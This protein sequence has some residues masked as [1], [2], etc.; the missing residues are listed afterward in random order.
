MVWAPIC[1]ATWPVT[2]LTLCCFGTEHIQ[3]NKQW[4]YCYSYDCQD[5]YPINEALQ[6]ITMYPPSITVQCQPSFITQEDEFLW[7]KAYEGPYGKDDISKH[8][9]C[10]TENGHMVI[11]L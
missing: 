1:A 11:S 7:E 5:H 10:M 6:D 2:F 4:W 8:D 3:L 9:V